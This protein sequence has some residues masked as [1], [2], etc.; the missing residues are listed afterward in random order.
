MFVTKLLSISP[1]LI[2]FVYQLYDLTNDYFKYNFSIELGF[3][4]QSKTLPSITICIDDRDKLGYAPKYELFT[5]CT[6]MLINGSRSDCNLSGLH[7]REKGTKICITYF[8]KVDNYY[9]NFI[10]TT[11]TFQM[12]LYLYSK[13]NVKIHPANT[14]SH[15]EHDNI[16]T[17]YR[18]WRTI[19]D[20]KKVTRYLL[21]APYSTNCHKYDGKIGPR[22][23]SHCMLEYMKR[24]ELEQCKHNYYWIQYEFENYRKVSDYYS[25]FI[26]S[27][28]KCK[29]KFNYTL[30]ANLC[31]QDC[32]NVKYDILETHSFSEYIYSP[33]AQF[34]LDKSFN[35][36][37]IYK[38][39]L[40]M[41]IYLSNIGG[42]ITMYFSVSLKKMIEFIFK[43][44]KKFKIT[45]RKKFFDFIDIIFR[46]LIYSI[47]FYQI[48]KLIW[49]Y[50]N[51]NLKEADMTCSP[52]PMH[53][54]PYKIQ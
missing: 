39:N 47:M 26:Y 7:A 53:Y 27:N 33:L 6:R 15:F 46:F 8:D 17:V 13:M 51:E 41:I 24:L 12:G 14:L 40:T 4:T 50:L 16:Y 29:T 48:Y 18:A 5:I 32:I 31:K 1:I 25:Y 3:D 38:P 49:S 30:L 28:Y 42:L 20:L 23:Q 11:S 9:Q 34:N 2:L 44:F 22:S 54:K 36:E 21:E 43:R 52:Y 45:R 35:V 19:F 10:D 37:L